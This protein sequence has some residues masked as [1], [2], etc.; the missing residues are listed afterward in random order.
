M[1][2][3]MT[4]ALRS[5]RELVMARSWRQGRMLGATSC[6]LAVLAVGC[7]GGEADVSAPPEAGPPPS[8]CVARQGERPAKA[9]LRCAEGAVAF[10][11]TE[12]ATGTGVVVEA[13]GARYLLTNQH[14][15]DP[16]DAAGVT[17]GGA[18]FE[19]VEVVGIDAA[20]DIA[21]LGPLTGDDLP[22]PLSLLDGTDVERGDDVFLVGFPGDTGSDGIQATIAAGIVSRVRSAE[23]F[24]QAFIQ[25]DAAIGGGQS[26]GPLFDGDG[27]LIGIAGLSFA[28]EFALALT[29]RDV[30]A[31]V[32]RI[33]AGQGDEYLAVPAATREGE[34]TTTGSLRITDASDGQVLFLPAAGADRTWNL[35]VDA[36]NR[37]VVA[38][39]TFVEAEPLALSASTNEVLADVERRL[40][41]ASGGA[42]D[43]ASDLPGLVDMGGGPE[44]AAR[45]TAP[46]TFE[47]PVDAGESAIVIV[48]VP[49]TDAPLDVPWTSDLP[50]SPASRPIGSEVLEVGD[51]VDRVVGGFDTA[52]DVVMDL[53]AGQEV[54]VHVHASQGDPG[55][56]VFRPGQALDHLTLA[57][58]ERAGIEVV[59]DNDDGLYGLGAEVTVEAEVAGEHRFRVYSND[60]NSVKVRIS[61]VDC[62]AATCPA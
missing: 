8:G 62:A 3:A 43:D 4:G 60:Y 47:I 15:I 56:M 24:D 12:A 34:G 14:V 53:D 29:A 46:G 50:L 42:G 16:F 27:G 13:G 6:A 18:T 33:V 30:R 5:G 32:E 61:S 25:T 1:L 57:D 21:L 40:A 11:E 54:Q 59:D 38:V 45:E 7:G 17:V 39:E 48:G 49:L 2:S 28:E 10:V 51:E 36:A 22:D 31:S 58:P 26:G 19:A 44:L 52:H 35:T 41:E 9:V 20:A 37:P 23:G 55:V